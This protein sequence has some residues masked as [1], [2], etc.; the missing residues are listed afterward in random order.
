MKI[1]F[2]TLLLASLLGA[3]AATA[4]SAARVEVFKSPYCGCCGEWV[5]H[6]QAAGFVVETRDVNDV[7]AIRKQLGMP[8][9]Y[10]SCHTAR[11]GGY[12]VEGHVPAADVKRLLAEKPRALGLAVP[13]MPP[14][15][16]GME[17]AHPVPYD[18]LLVKRDGGASVFAR[19]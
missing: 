11:V 14:G 17:S 10:G 3:G 19:H 9:R 15:S 16:P 5:K 13:A 2:R 8:E 1:I 7:P 18:T 6:M 4:Q 12:L